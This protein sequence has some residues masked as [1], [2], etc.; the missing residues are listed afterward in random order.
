MGHLYANKGFK[1]LTLKTTTESRLLIVI[2]DINEIFIKQSTV[3]GHIFDKPT[4]QCY[5]IS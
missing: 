5:A 1:F 2:L 3:L 4:L